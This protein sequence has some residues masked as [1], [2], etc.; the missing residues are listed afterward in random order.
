M[1]QNLGRITGIGKKR[2]LGGSGTGEGTPDVVKE[3]K[4]CMK[5]TSGAC[6]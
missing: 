2:H 6:G 5:K 4:A 1:V 3:F